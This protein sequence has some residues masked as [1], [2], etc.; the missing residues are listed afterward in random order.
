[1]KTSIIFALFLLLQ[2]PLQ[3]IMDFY[4]NADREYYVSLAKANT[5]EAIVRHWSSFIPVTPDDTIKFLIPS[6]DTAA[7][8]QEQKIIPLLCVEFKD[9]DE[10]GENDDVYSHLVI[11]SMIVFVLAGVD[12]RM[13]IV[14]LYHFPDSYLGM[15]R[16]DEK[17]NLRNCFSSYMRAHMKARRRMRNSLRGVLRE[18]PEALLRCPRLGGGGGLSLSCYRDFIYIKAGKAFLYR[19]SEK[20]SYE[21]NEYARNLVKKTGSLALWSNLDMPIIYESNPGKTEIRRAG[22]TPKEY[23]LIL[24]AMGL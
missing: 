17:H 21:L 22:Y 16:L 2:T 18:K 11:D 5:K 3:Q 20:K 23:N 7:L 14:N 12:E 9:M 15:V 4:L 10:F 13:R 19:S 6:P 1:M 24:Q 8:F